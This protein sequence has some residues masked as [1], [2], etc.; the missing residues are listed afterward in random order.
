MA[1]R[2]GRVDGS[3]TSAPIVDPAIAPARTA[4]PEN[5]EVSLFL[6]SYNAIFAS[7]LARQTSGDQLA[8]DLAG[9]Q[10]EDLLTRVEGIKTELKAAVPS[11]NRI[12]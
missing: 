6:A 4:F 11:T 2:E 1:Y 3:S 9:A 5:E 12:A 10:M 8:R 7:L